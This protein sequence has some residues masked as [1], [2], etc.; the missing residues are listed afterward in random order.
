MGIKE[1]VRAGATLSGK[2]QGME[3]GALV[4][5]GYTVGQTSLRASAPSRTNADY[6]VQR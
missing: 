6:P 3:R 2:T 5:F 1:R 4:V